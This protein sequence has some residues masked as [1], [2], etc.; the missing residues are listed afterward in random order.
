MTAA[1]GFEVAARPRTVYDSKD[2]TGRK[3]HGRKRVRMD[4]LGEFE[5]ERPTVY[6]TVRDVVDYEVTPALG[7]FADCYDALGIARDCWRYDEGLGGF[8]KAVDEDGFWES[9]IAHD[10]TK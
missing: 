7:E 10:V 9:A 3:A 4:W 5:D 8:V 2:E 1:P 6:K